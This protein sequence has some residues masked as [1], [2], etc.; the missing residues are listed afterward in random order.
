LFV[1]ETEID[2]P[3]RLCV[4]PSLAQLEQIVDASSASLNAIVRMSPW[5]IRPSVAMP[6]PH[7][8]R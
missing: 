7:S 1:T 2:P 4:L 5:P 6:S 3:D 8:T